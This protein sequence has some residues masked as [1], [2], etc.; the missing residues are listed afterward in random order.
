MLVSLVAKPTPV[1]SN[2]L[3]SKL[4]GGQVCVCVSFNNNV[5]VIKGV[6]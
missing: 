6:F 4:R 1:A 2:S 5:A 3:E